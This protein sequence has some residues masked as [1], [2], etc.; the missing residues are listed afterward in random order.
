MDEQKKKRLSLN[1]IF[2]HNTFVLIFSFCVALISWFMLAAGNEDTNRLITDVPIDVKLSLAAEE[3]GFRVFSMSYDAA[4]L[5]ISGSNLI[6]NKLTAEDFEVSVSLNLTSAKLTGN[7]LQKATAQVRAAKKSPIADYDIVSINPEE[8]TVEYDRYKEVTFPIEHGDIEYSTDPN[9]YPGT[10]SFSAETVIVS[11]PESSV[12]KISRAA[13]SYKLSDPLRSDA[14]FT[15]PVRL[16]DQNNQEITDISA[17]Y[18]ET[19][20]DTVDVVIPVLARK[21]VTIVASTV[22]QPKGFSDTR[23][24]VSPATIDIAGAADV[25]AGINEIQLETPID[26]A[27]LELA[28]KNT[29]TMDI[30]LPSGVRNISAVGENT[31]SQATVTINLAGFMDSIVTVSADNFQLSN[32]PVGKDVTID[33]QLLEVTL[34]GSEAQIA[35]LTGDMLSVQ[36]DLTNFANR[37]GS[38]EVPAT[39]V[40]AGS[41]T[42]TCWVL[43]RYTVL[44]QILDRAAIQGRAVQANASAEDES[45]DGLVAQPQE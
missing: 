25:L 4:D 26:F 28:Q 16:Y 11:G 42:D 44:V 30:P 10:P 40:I 39:I 34:L 3:G 13:V 7:T 37:T 41:G 6:T 27:D 1:G 33:T 17:M 29:F 19:D 43:G 14:S 38:V 2:Y 12:N 24:T 8:I 21:T 18:L 32:Q 22:H 5:D 36:I 35:K 45:S 23:I 15:C 20:V 31:V 9:F